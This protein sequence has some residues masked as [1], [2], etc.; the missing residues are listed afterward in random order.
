MT[1][2]TSMLCLVCGKYYLTFE[3]YHELWIVE[4]ST[5][6]EQQRQGCTVPLC[7]DP[8]CLAPLAVKVAV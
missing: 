4:N 7:L 3:I 5:T 2:T 6:G 1:F 8:A